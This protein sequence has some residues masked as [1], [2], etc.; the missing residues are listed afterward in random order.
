MIR[1]VYGNGGSRKVQ[2]LA[3]CIYKGLE[4]SCVR[5]SQLLLFCS[6]DFDKRVN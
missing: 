6:E 4:L 5:D 1:L 2:A 3:L